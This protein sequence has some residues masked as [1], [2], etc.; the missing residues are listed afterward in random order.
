MGRG[1]VPSFDSLGVRYTVT[2]TKTKAYDECPSGSALYKFR[3][4]IRPMPTSYPLKSETPDNGLSLLANGPI[5]LVGRGICH[6]RFIS[7]GLGTK[8]KGWIRSNFFNLVLCC[9][10]GN[11]PAAPYERHLAGIIS[12]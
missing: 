2:R 3:L 11:Y 9:G 7:G 1:I 4:R 8:W 12:R 5:Y 10:A 6:E